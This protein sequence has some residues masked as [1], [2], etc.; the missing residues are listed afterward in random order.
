MQFQP[1]VMPHLITAAMYSAL[2]SQDL[3][4]ATAFQRLYRESNDPSALGQ[5][6]EANRFWRLQLGSMRVCTLDVRS[7]LI[8]DCD[9]N[10]WMRLFASEVAPV[11]AAF[12]LPREQAVAGLSAVG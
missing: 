11:I 7:C 8:D 10:D 9:P 2:A 12:H 5:I 3:A 1:Q 6:R 4:C